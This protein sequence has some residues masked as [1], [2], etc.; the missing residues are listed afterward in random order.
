MLCVQ[1]ADLDALQQNISFSPKISP[2]QSGEAW[3]SCAPHQQWD[4]HVLLAGQRSTGTPW[5]HLEKY[6]RHQWWQPL[7]PRDTHRMSCGGHT[8]LALLCQH[9]SHWDLLSSVFYWNRSLNLERQLSSRKHTVQACHTDLDDLKMFLNLHV[10][11]SFMVSTAPALQKI[12]TLQGWELDQ[13]AR[14]SR[15]W[16]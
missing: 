13:F 2:E 1:V 16:D 9:K 4:H 10:L 11:P 12:P 5:G 15:T 7:W 6:S 3:I 8:P 14:S